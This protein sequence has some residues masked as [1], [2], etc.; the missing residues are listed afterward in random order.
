MKKKTS[1]KNFFVQHVVDA[2]TRKKTII[3][4]INQIQ[5]VIH[6]TM[7][8]VDSHKKNHL[9]TTG[10]I[11]T[12]TI[13]LLDIYNILEKCLND[14]L[15]DQ[16]NYDGIIEKIQE[17]V[18]TLSGIIS[19]YGTRNITDLLFITF[20]TEFV[21]ELHFNDPVIENK[22]EMIKRY[23]RP[24]GYKV[25]SWKKPKTTKAVTSVAKTRNTE[26]CID[27]INTDMPA[28]ENY[29]NLEC[30][31]IDIPNTIHFFLKIHG[32]RI[33]IHNEQQQKTIIIKAVCKN[34][35]LEAI[36]SSYIDARIKS[37]H[38]LIDHSTSY[39]KL[40]C[41]NMLD[42]LML[43]D[44]LILGDNDIYK[45]NVGISQ[46]IRFVTIGDID[47]IIKKFLEMN[48]YTQRNIFVNVFSSSDETVR[49]VAYI[50][51]DMITINTM[52]Q[53]D[54]HN[55]NLIY[56]S[57]PWKIKT[58]LKDSTKNSIR[59]TQDIIKKYEVSP[60]TLE[61]KIYLLKLPD[62]IKEKAFNRLRE[63][64]GRPD[65]S[66][67]KARQYLEGLL[68]IPF[69]H[70]RNEPILNRITDIHSLILNSNLRIASINDTLSGIDLPEMPKKSKYNN[71]EIIHYIKGF[72]HILSE[73]LISYLKRNIN[74][75][76]L[77][78]T[79]QTCE[80]AS[81]YT[82]IPYKKTRTD[83]IDY[84][85]K[86][87]ENPKCDMKLKCTV[88]EKMAKN[89]ND[90]LLQVC[91][92]HNHVIESINYVD[93]DMKSITD[94]LNCSIYGHD[95]A[96]NQILK[97][98][99]QWINGKPS[100]YC[101]GFEGSP[102][103]GKTSL[104]KMGISKCLV[105][106]D[107]TP[108]PFA[109]IALGGSCNGSTLEGHN[110]TYV[111]ALWGRIVDILMETQ[112]MN[113]I[114]YI[115][116]LDKVSNTESGKEIIGILMHLIDSTQ[117]DVF[118]DKYF[119]GINIDL[120]KVLFIFSYNEPDKIDRVLLDRIHRIKFDNLTT[121]DKLVVL[122]RHI[123]P[124]ICDRMG[125]L[126]D[127]VIIED[128]I[129]KHIIDCYTMEPG[130][131]KLKEILF[132]IFGEIN[133]ELLRY[134]NDHPVICPIH[135][136][137][138]LLETKYLKNYTK[139]EEKRIH[140]SPGVGHINGLWANSLGKGGITPIEAVFCPANVFLEL[141]LT[142]LQGDVMKESMNVAKNIAWSLTPDSKKAELL[143][144]FEKT[145][146]GGIHIH[147]PDGGVSKDGP[148][149]GA[150]ITCALYSLFNGVGIKPNIAITGE[151]DLIGNV[152]A[153]GGL[154]SKI[155]GGIRAGVDTFI[156]PSANSSN[157]EKFTVKYGS[158]V[159]LTNINCIMVTQIKDVFKHVFVE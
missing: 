109:F 136:T 70:Y 49:Y 16:D 69:N 9:F 87:L 121:I 133:I 34:V 62:N 40:E 1:P 33:I 158:S 147:C 46:D 26:L 140:E 21:N 105:D 27:K 54:A 129:L 148:S 123:I 107:G 80:F 73:K 128:D 8:S 24:I 29:N 130:I 78:T 144:I 32:I 113:P 47:T 112:C 25:I 63:V 145:H 125:I 84:I 65:E 92:E 90:Q 89:T 139:I 52:E 99:C 19:N 22:Y 152:T 12:T 137:N 153:I 64:K 60:V 11:M 28:F 75:Y 94:T 131:R 71:N 51:Y 85:V 95:N 149:A 116:E 53:M 7:L 4:K 157:Y 102:G 68:K 108:R 97:I 10:E 119:S 17:A 14:I 86:F 115:D 30:L 143:S 44:W 154:D 103:I 150:A 72:K 96:K 56:D 23:V 31:N 39:T 79:I 98:M 15:T 135:I 159:D 20:G 146:H 76:T 41:H 134:C 122:R 13:S 59:Y 118:Q 138:E 55:Q 106:E 114:I 142:G 74:K 36:R 43:K 6:E 104:A 111:N 3:S 117:N 93:K 101:F 110:Y 58:I 18:D 156:F 141:N 48:L 81:G 124:E 67:A 155:L 5:N 38:R 126:V 42:T 82:N 2:A 100:G 91:N 120:S 57:F 132:D 127:S 37:L 61:Q 35:P 77:K 88:F 45:K 151:I 83:R 66:S 50:L